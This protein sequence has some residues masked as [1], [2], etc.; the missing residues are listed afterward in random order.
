MKGQDPQL[1][2]AGELVMEQIRTLQKQL[3]KRPP[4][5][6]AYPKN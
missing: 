4:D 1:E 3:P 2:K 5:L 6:P